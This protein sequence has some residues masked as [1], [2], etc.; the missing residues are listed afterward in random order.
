M[1]NITTTKATIRKRQ[2]RLKKAMQPCLLVGHQLS[3]VAFNLKQRNDI[4]EDIRATLAS[5]Q[6]QWD[7]AK[8]SIPNWM[9]K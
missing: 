3:N 5:L 1:G 4:P 6:K 9:R 7:E 2:T 8:K